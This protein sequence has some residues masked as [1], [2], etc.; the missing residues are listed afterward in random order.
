MV[1]L[2]PVKRP[3]R[4]AL[5]ATAAGLVVACG[6]RLVA[7][8]AALPHVQT[9]AIRPLD[10]ASFEPGVE[11]LVTDALR[12][13][14]LRRG[15]VEVVADPER[16]D[17]VI[18]GKIP[19][20]ET[21]SQTFSSVKLALEYELV[22]QLH[23]E[24]RKRDGSELKIDSGALRESEIYQASADIELLRRNRREALRR[25]AGVLAARAH[26][27]LALSLTP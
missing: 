16:A 25:L 18:G 7:P 14:F 11:A 12:R 1:Y 5:A 6:Y 9:L 27:A 20:L 10:N 2:R 17:L 23:L 19:P 15:G 24:A 13:E 3:L 8:R 21:H 4:L 26:D 22:M